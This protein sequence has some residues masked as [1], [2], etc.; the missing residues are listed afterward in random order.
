V[1]VTVD[2][3]AWLDAAAC[4]GLPPDLFFGAEGEQQHEKP[5]REAAAKRICARCPVRVA[6]LDDALA[7]GIRFGVFGGAGEDERRLLRENLRRRIRAAE[8]RAS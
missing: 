3:L 7:A 6:C 8:R 2:D 1:T 4:V 5:A